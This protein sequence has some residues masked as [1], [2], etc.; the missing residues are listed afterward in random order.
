MLTESTVPSKA[1]D[2]KLNIPFNDLLGIRVTRTHRDGVTVQCDIQPE[3]RNSHGVLHGGV[4]ATLVDVAVGMAAVHHFGGK[5]TLTTV[6]LK[7]NYFLP[8]SEGRVTARARL[9][10]LGS[11]L[12]VGSVEV[13][14]HKRR[15]AAFG[16]ATYKILS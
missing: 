10:R 11:S 9:L 1:A 16:T 14:D 6:E 15:L 2:P 3:L 13:K 8:I 12:V 7:V 4:T 5:R